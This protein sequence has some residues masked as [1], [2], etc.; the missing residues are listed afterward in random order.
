MSSEDHKGSDAF[1]A[2]QSP[3]LLRI[4]EMHMLSTLFEPIQAQ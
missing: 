4:G 2:K 3:R 1:V